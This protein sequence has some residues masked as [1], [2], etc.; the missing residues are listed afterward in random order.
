MNNSLPNQKVSQNKKSYA[1][2]L[3]GDADSKVEKHEIK[4]KHITLSDEELVQVTDPQDV[5]I[6]KVKNIKTMNNLHR[7]CREEGFVDLKIHHIGGLWLWLQFQNVGTCNA[8]KNN[9]TLASFFTTIKSVSKNF[10]VD[11]RMVS[12]SMSL[13]RVCVATRQKSFISHLVHVT[14]R[15]EDYEAYVQE[16]G[17]WSINLDDSSS[18]E[19]ETNSKM[20]IKFDNNKDANLVSESDDE[21]D[22]QEALNVSQEDNDVRKAQEECIHGNEEVVPKTQMDRMVNSNSSD[23]SRT[24]SFEHYNFFENEHSSSSFKSKSGKCPTH[25]EILK[26]NGI[27]GISVIHE[28]SRL[29]EVGEKLGYDVKGCHNSLQKLIDR[30]G[31]LMS[32]WGNYTFDYACSLSRGRSGGLISV[33][34]LNHFIKDQIW[35]DEWYI[36]VKGRW[37]T[38]D[39]VFFMINV[40]GPQETGEKI[41]LWNRLLQFMSNHEGHFVLFGDLNEVR[42]ESERG[43]EFHRPPANNFNAFIT[44]A[45]LL[46]LPLGGR[47]FTWMNKA[48][49]KMSKLDRFL[50]SQHVT[51]IF[52]DVKVMALPR[53]WSDH[54]PILLYCDKIDYGPVPFKFF[55]SWLQREGF[56][57]CIRKAY[58]ECLIT[59]SQISFHEKLKHL[60]KTIKDWNHQAK[61]NYMSRKHEVMRKLKDI[62]EKIDS[63]TA[64][65]SE[66][67]DRMKLLKEQ[68]DI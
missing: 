63:N 36:I 11:E 60:K 52:P 16:F 50:I 28:I 48:G 21:N 35:C 13:G 44:D 18:Q 65:D 19:S 14:I 61:C 6:V 39:S 64:L 66:K 45:G 5:A 57:D 40:Y 38:S 46:E 67:E 54:S 2:T 62:E 23:L 7:L 43:T 33:W 58:E 8:F 30:I 26:C 68:D 9:H 37:T 51:D 12:S 1:S 22:I 56:D 17:S 55:H 31:V 27:R 47:N 32:M 41:A 3:Y 10:C 29:I 20:D 24:P 34:D 59:N 42:D 25:F 4:R 15:G 53:G 49:S